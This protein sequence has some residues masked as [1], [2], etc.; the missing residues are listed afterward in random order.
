MSVISELELL[1]HPGL[2]HDSEDKIRSFLLELTVLQLNP[3]ICRATIEL[4]KR[5]RLKL[6]D[7]IIAA[8]AKTLEADLVTNDQSLLKLSELR[9]TS[10]KLAP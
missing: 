4:R 6:P 8:T 1:S 7:A 5:Y 2:E 10:A 9:P 3:E